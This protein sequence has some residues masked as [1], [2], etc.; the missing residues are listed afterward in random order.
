MT[1]SAKNGAAAPCCTNRVGCSCPALP[2]KTGVCCEA[3]VAR[4]S[5][6]L[7]TRWTGTLLPLMVQL[8]QVVLLHVCLHA[9]RCVSPPCR[10][11]GR[12]SC[13][14][15]EPCRPT[16]ACAQHSTTS[17]PIPTHLTPPAAA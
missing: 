10:Q 1:V 7:P 3:P 2:H 15:P 6:L 12:T 14:G 4:T 8:L 11:F 9:L 13:Q 5:R 17:P 16:K